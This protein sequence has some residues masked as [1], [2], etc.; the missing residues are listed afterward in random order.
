[1]IRTRWLLAW[2]LCSM[3]LVA[4]CQETLTSSA[5]GSVFLGPALLEPLEVG[6][7]ILV[8]AT[9]VSADGPGPYS[10]GT[11]V[12]SSDDPSIAS[13]TSLPTQSLFGEQARARVVAVGPGET[14]IRVDTRAGQATLA[15][16]VVAASPGS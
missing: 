15:I 4:A 13:V 11:P 2:T 14:T 1:M 12:W 3:S 10:L 5:R 8:T 6:D 9:G 7:S 16:P